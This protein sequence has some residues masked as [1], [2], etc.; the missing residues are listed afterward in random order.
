MWT[1]D[2]KTNPA[3]RHIPVGGG[4]LIS[5]LLCLVILLVLLFPG[6]LAGYPAFIPLEDRLKESKLTLVGNIRQIRIGEH[7][8]GNKIVTLQIE[9]RE[10]L[11]G[12]LTG[13]E[14][15]RVFHLTYLIFPRSDES[16]LIKPPE[17][18]EHIFFLN[19]KRVVDAKGRVGYAIV[20]FEPRVY[21]IETVTG[22]DL[23]KLRARASLED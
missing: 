1:S 11:K 15:S 17:K 9:V 10:V 14:S 23:E 21:A 7:A 20:L 16:H 6:N 5:A 8:R 22:V 3:L 13:G 12:K 4:V 19:R 2:L 18:G